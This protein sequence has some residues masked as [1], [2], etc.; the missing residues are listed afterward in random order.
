MSSQGRYLLPRLLP[1]RLTFPRRLCLGHFHVVLFEVGAMP[2]IPLG[3]HLSGQP[4][5]ILADKTAFELVPLS[6]KFFIL[7]A[8]RVTHPNLNLLA[9]EVLSQETPNHAPDM[10][11]M[12]Y[13]ALP[14]Y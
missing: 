6:Q 14:N 3:F 13:L 10:S 7:Y 4:A 11:S 8:F 12:S 1:E 9:C 2:P 5:F